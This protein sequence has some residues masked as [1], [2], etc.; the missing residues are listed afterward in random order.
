MAAEGTPESEASRR[1]PVAVS[2][3]DPT[4]AASA[5]SV[6]PC[7]TFCTI[8][9]AFA[10]SLLEIWSSRHFASTWLRTSSSGRSREGVMPS[11]SYQT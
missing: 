2:T 7:S 6:P 9:V 3:F 4:A 1:K 5:A 8:S 10:R 11:T